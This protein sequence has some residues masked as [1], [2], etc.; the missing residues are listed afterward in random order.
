MYREEKYLNS[1]TIGHNFFKVTVDNIYNIKY[2]SDDLY[3]SQ[4]NV[5]FI[6]PD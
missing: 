6:K 3:K 2:M 5:Y 4:L 1:T